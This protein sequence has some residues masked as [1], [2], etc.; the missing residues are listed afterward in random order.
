MSYQNLVIEQMEQCEREEYAEIY[1]QARAFGD[2]H[3]EAHA[4]ATYYARQIATD[5]Y[6]HA[7]SF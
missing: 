6:A 2:T 1:K 3:E 7:Y 4:A 5:A